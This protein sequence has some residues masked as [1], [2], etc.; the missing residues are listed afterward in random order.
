MGDSNSLGTKTEQI[1]LVRRLQD[2][3]K[4]AHIPIQDRGTTGN[5]P[6]TDC[7]VPPKAIPVLVATLAPCTAGRQHWSL[8]VPAIEYR[9]DD[10]T[11][12]LLKFVG[13]LCVCLESWTARAKPTFFPSHVPISLCPSLSLLPHYSVI[14]ITVC[15]NNACRY[16]E[17]YR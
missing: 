7:H 8:S 17:S 9:S 2:F 15:F 5:E 13:V 10:G 4:S 14:W 16:F 1:S 6:P 3:Y 12:D 11:M